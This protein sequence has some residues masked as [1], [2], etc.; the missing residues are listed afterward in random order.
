MG[1]QLR[2]PLPLCMQW[3]GCTHAAVPMC[4]LHE[5]NL[6]QQG[7]EQQA[8]KHTCSGTSTSRNSGGAWSKLPVASACTHALPRVSMLRPLTNGASVV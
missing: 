6:F 1:L 8:E 7:R 3:L 5:C 2:Y 4:A